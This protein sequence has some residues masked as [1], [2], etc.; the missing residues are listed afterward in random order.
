MSVQKRVNGSPF[1]GV[2]EP[3]Q[4]GEH[5]LTTLTGS[6]ATAFI[7]AQ[8]AKLLGLRVIEVVDMGKHGR[9]LSA[10]PADLL[11]D[12]HNP[13][14]AVEIIRSV[15]ENSLRFGIDTIGRQTAEYLQKTLHPGDSQQINDSKNTRKSYSHL[16]GLS[17]IPK[18]AVEGV[19]HHAVPIKLYH[20]V[21]EIGEALMTW[22]EKLLETSSIT[23]PEVVIVDGGLESVNAS[24]DKMRKGEIS[25]KRLVVK[26]A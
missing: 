9:T 6:S 17:G 14:R 10:G 4:H 26:L 22:L 7:T 19:K 3:K 11:V 12:S 16:V 18:Q 15:T 23:P 25:G 5:L 24:L 8:L 13:E 21:G 1:G 20:E 2:S